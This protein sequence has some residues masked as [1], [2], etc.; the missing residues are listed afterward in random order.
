MGVDFL[1][2]N[3][4]GDTFPDCGYYVSCRGCS[5]FHWIARNWCCKECAKADGYKKEEYEIDDATVEEISCKY[6]RK[7]DV[8]D[9]V[10]FDFLLR[11]FKLTR[12]KALKM[13]LG[14]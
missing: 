2:C 5:D 8:E 6:C 1:V 14:K 13:Y 10:L 12:K 11:H 3:Y 4:C 7:E 9:S